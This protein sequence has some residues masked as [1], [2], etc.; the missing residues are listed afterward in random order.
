MTLCNSA[1]LN[2][3]AFMQGAAGQLAV[4][5]AVLMGASC[6]DLPTW[7]SRQVVSYLE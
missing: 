2:S 7:A 5:N 3:Y 4:A 1:A 6:L